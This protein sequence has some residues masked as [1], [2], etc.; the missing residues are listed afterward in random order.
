MNEK[1]EKKLRKEN[2]LQTKQITEI[3]NTVLEKQLTMPFKLRWRIALKIL[4]GKQQ[5][6]GEVK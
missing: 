6:K 2:K 3:F 4:I 5:K 1:Q